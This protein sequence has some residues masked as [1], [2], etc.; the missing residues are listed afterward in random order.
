[1]NKWLLGLRK[2]SVVIIVMLL[3]SA[4]KAWGNLSDDLYKIALYIAGGFVGLDFIGK[5]TGS[6]TDPLQKT[7]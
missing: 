7:K 4:L 5:F 1:M 3:A 6:E 2:W